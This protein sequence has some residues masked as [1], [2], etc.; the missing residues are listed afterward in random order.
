MVISIFYGTITGNTERAADLIRRRLGPEVR[1]FDISEVELEDVLRADVLLFGAP[2][3]N[4]GEL[5]DDWVYFLPRLDGL[6]LTGKRVALFGLGDA[7][8]YPK[9]FLDALGL[10]WGELKQLGAPELV[11]V[12]PTKDYDFI[13]SAGLIDE[14]HFIGLG[15][16]VD[17]EPDKHEARIDAWLRQIRAECGIDVSKDNAAE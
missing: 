1:M 12:W 11:G 4:I 16:D 15:L 10:I 9:N 6:D 14:D 5:P 3:W 2:T 7:R 17:N 13:D 8:G